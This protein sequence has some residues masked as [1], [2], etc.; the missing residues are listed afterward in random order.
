MKYEINFSMLK[1]KLWISI[2]IKYK[3]IIYFFFY[4]L[5]LLLVYFIS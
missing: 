1:E 2:E 4:S 5:E 3:E